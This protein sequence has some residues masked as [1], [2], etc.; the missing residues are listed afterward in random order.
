MRSINLLYIS[1]F[2]FPILSFAQPGAPDTQ[3]GTN[4]WVNYVI[5]ENENGFKNMGIQPDGKLIVFRRGYLG[6]YNTNGTLDNTFGTEGWRRLDY[7]AIDMVVQTD[8]SIL[9]LLGNSRIYK[10]AASNGAIDLTWGE[11]GSVGIE[12]FGVQLGFRS[13]ALDTKGRII[14]A[15]QAVIGTAPDMI[16]TTA[17]ARLK[18]DGSLDTDFNGGGIKI[19]I[20][21]DDEERSSMECGVDGSDKIIVSVFVGQSIYDRKDV[22]FKYNTDGKLDLGF[23]GGDGELTTDANIERLKVDVS[24]KIAYTT[25]SRSDASF[26]L[27]IFYLNPD[28]TPLGA[29]SIHQRWGL[30]SITFQDDGKLVVAGFGNSR[31]FVVRFNTDGSDDQSFFNDEAIVNILP[32]ADIVPREMIYYN[33]RLFVAGLSGVRFG[34]NVN[35]IVDANAFILALDGSDKRLK[36]NGFHAG[37]LDQNADADKCYKTIN[38]SRYDPI[39]VP[40]TATGTVQYEMK[41]NNVVIEQGTGSVNGKD[42]QVGQT[43]VTYT[44]TDITSH[45]CI[46]TVRISDRVPPVAKTKNI[47]AQLNASGSVSITAADIDDGSNDPCGIKSLTINK[48]NFSCSDVGANTITFK[49]TDN[50]NNTATSTATVT[51]EDKVVPDARSKNITISLNAN[52]N[53]SITAAQIDDGSTDA[54]GIKSL[55]LSKTTFDCSNKGSNQVTLTATDNNNNTSSSIATVTVVDDIHPTIV[56]IVPNPAFLWPSDRKMKSVLISATLSDNCP[57]STY[58]ITNVVIKEGTFAGDNVGPDWEITGDHT[59][60][61]RAEIPK[62]GVKRIYTVTITCTDAAGNSTT[63]TT[64]IVVAHAVTSPLSGAT[65]KVGSTVNLASSFWDVAGKKHSAKWLIDDKTTISGTVT[66]PSGLN[67]GTVTGSYKFN[68]A[69]V[70]KIKVNMTD[71]NGFTTYAN[72]NDNLDAIVVVYDPNGGFTYG[73][74]NFVSPPGALIAAPSATAETSYGFTVNYYKNASLP[75]GETQFEFK[76]G[77]FE[78]NALNFEYLIISNSMAQFKGT[79]KIIGGQSGV[80]FT[81]TVTDGQLDGS[82]IDKIRMKIYNKNNGK[83]I[84]DNQPGA[85]DAALPT[86]AVGANSIVVISSMNSSL[87]SANSSQKTEMEAAETKAINDLNVIAYPNPSINNFYITVQASTKEKITMQV[88]DM[89]GR[90]IETRNVSAN[91]IIRFGDRYRAGTYFVRVIQGKQ[92]K[93]LKLVKLSD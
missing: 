71:Q 1:L 3:Y 73:G 18:P 34:N 90:I 28:G 61:L 36:C 63:G 51:V 72:T 70:Y 25:A 8:G 88:M 42:F 52:G 91:S 92:H 57:G 64:D 14:L 41:R 49:A 62:K 53:A 80:A 89:Y 47:T 6:R 31:L 33:K 45:S 50:S 74:G 4:G 21:L 37:D 68:A 16:I 78:F 32:G 48:T 10:H 40:T 67:N 27:Q 43:E 35:V 44:Y 56:S 24:G 9:L 85:S 7:G 26:P 29:R 2:F 46:F 58:R 75:K 87:T 76:V 15:G 12:L 19:Q 13:M 93:E 60:N 55:S 81:M 23:G 66:E 22:I 17:V 77:E 54:C 86:Q 83:I 38:N 79:G 39:F 82:G 59:V 69:G 20:F 5:D 84:Y 30:T 65:V 11:N